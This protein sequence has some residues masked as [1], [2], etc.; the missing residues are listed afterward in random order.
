M[1][2]IGKF[3]KWLALSVLAVILLVAVFPWTSVVKDQI[4]AEKFRSWLLAGKVTLDLSEPDAGFLLPDTVNDARLIMLSEIHGFA[5]V[6]KIDLA[7]LRYLNE[8]FGVRSYLAELSP[9]QAMAFNTY[10]GGGSDKDV[11]AVFGHWAEER[12]QWGNREFF[13][14][15]TALRTFNSQVSDDQKVWFIGVDQ[16]YDREW[17]SKIATEYVPVSTAAFGS[18]EGVMAINAALL[19]LGLER[20]EDTSRYGHILPNIE[21]LLSVPAADAEIFYGLWG[22]FHGSKM[23]VNGAEPLAMRLNK[24]GGVFEGGVV[25]IAT[26]CIDGCFNMM[27]ASAAPPPFQPAN[28]EEYV[29]M[30]MNYD[31]VYLARLRGVSDVRNAMG[32]DRVALFPVSLEGSPYTSS[33]RLSKQS[34]YLMLLQKFDYGGSADEVMDYLIVMRGSAAL[35]PWQGE[36]YDVT[37]GGAAKAGIN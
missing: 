26:L 15:L 9:A 30:P 21:S 16:I 13:S 19:R 23:T 11:M 28:G 32:D 22:L 1:R 35:T 34:G 14:K 31:D 10:I 20:E 18:Q 29:L 17:A 8:N 12:A 37:G 6:Q 7:L 4:G 25:S 3:F 27:P 33:G 24:E 36:A 2:I 5:A